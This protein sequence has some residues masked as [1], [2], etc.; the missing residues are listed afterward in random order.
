[1]LKMNY[2]TDKWDLNE[3]VCPCDVH[4]NAWVEEHRLRNQRIYHFGTG[5]HH[6]IGVRQAENGL[7][8]TVFAITASIEEYQAYIQLMS[9][10]SR[11]ARNYLAY[12][13][14]IYLSNPRLL[15]EFDVVTMFHLCEFFFPNTASAEYGGMTDRKMLDLFT[16]KTRR[17]GH[18][19]FYTRSCA[20]DHAKPVI[21]EWAREQPVERVGEFKTLLI[22]RKR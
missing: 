4:F 18:L 11:V 9:E 3:D 21:A 19:L 1:M 14:D 7:G 15:P 17:G 10:N 12:F 8:N 2:W 16:A 6:V 5:T 20:F 22:Y 13:G